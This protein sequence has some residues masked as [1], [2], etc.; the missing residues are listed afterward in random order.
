M[1]RKLFTQFI[2]EAQTESELKFWTQIEQMRGAYRYPDDEDFICEDI[3]G[4]FK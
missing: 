2:K 4:L 3:L 1:T